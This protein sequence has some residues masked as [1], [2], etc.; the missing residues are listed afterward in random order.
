MTVREW[1]RLVRETQD[2]VL[3]NDPTCTITA[4]HQLL[5]AIRIG[6]WTEVEFWLIL[7]REELAPPKDQHVWQLQEYRWVCVRCGADVPSL[8][9]DETG[10]PEEQFDEGCP[11][12]AC[13]PCMGAV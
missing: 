1:F 3:W 7:R 12:K 10:P 9:I 5:E 13:Q 8:D 2:A 4:Q 6:T 11:C